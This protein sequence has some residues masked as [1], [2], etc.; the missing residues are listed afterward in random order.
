MV[1]EMKSC[2]FCGQ[3]IESTAIVCHHCTRSQLSETQRKKYV[4]YIVEQKM[5]GKS[6]LRSNLISIGILISA[7]SIVFSGFEKGVV[8]GIIALV[9]VLIIWGGIM[10][11]FQKQVNKLNLIE[12]KAEYDDYKDKTAIRK[13]NEL[14][15]WGIILAAALT[16]PGTQ[17]FREYYVYH[18]P[19]AEVLAIYRENYFVFSVFKVRLRSGEEESYT[20]LLGNLGGF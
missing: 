15:F 18:H 13:S 2:Q 11:F 16:N 12:L 19:E 8:S 3:E 20:G 9:I 14:K 10:T 6:S 1:I 17:E 7:F 4:D 5:W